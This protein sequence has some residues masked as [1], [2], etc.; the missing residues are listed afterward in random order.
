MN[1]SELIQR[2]M[3]LNPKL[4]VKDIEMSVSEILKGISGSLVSRG[5]V[6]IRGFGS[7]KLNKQPARIARNPKNGD[8]VSIPAKDRPHFTPGK[9]L[10]ERVNAKFLES[11]SQSK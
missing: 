3:E 5:R 4:S 11:K 1:R 10:R 6:E 2:L 9:E 7:F 8:K